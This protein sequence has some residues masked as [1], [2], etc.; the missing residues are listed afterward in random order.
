MLRNSG[1]EDRNVLVESRDR[2]PAFCLSLMELLP[3]KEVEFCGIMLS[4]ETDHLCND[5]SRFMVGKNS[6]WLYVY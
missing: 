1:F 4:E 6:S 3:R 5:V 2:T